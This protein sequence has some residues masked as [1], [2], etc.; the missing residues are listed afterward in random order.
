MAKPIEPKL[1]RATCESM[2]N[3]SNVGVLVMCQDSEPYAVP[4]NHAFVGGKL[5][6]H[7]A[8][9]GRKLDLIRANPKVSYVVQ[10]ELG[11]T[12]PAEA[13]MCHPDWE[14]VIAYGTARVVEEAQEL[15][16]AFLLFGRHYRPDFQ[17]SEDSLTTTR[18]IVMDI[19]TMT[20][21]REVKGEGVSYCTW[22]PEG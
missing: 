2:L 11:E 13:R 21:R 9:T 5:Y 20:T 8:P 3:G 1:D 10:Y 19:T 7:C 18:A 4:M 16:E 17:V 12:T 22:E 14:S 6:F 15:R